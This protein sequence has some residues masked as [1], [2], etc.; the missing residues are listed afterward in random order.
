MHLPLFVQALGFKKT[1]SGVICKDDI[2]SSGHAEAV[3]PVEA[4]YP[5]FIGH[6]GTVGHGGETC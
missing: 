5:A 1:T 3:I 4:V 2:K 6:V